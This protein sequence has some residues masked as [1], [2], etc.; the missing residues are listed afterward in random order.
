MILIS[1]FMNEDAVARLRADFEVHHDATLVDDTQRLY[2]A[3]KIADALIVRNRTQVDARCSR[4]AA[5]A[6]RRPARRRPRQHRRRQRAR[7]AH[8]SHSGYRRQRGAVAEYVIATA[9]LLLRGAYRSSAESPRTL[10]AGRCR[11][12]ARSPA[13]RSDWSASA[14]RPRHCAREHSARHARRRH[15][16]LL[17]RDDAGWREHDVERELSTQCWP[18]PTSSRCTFRSTRRRAT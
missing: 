16:A 14:H 2:A 15:D 13:R 4:R 11:K 6:R 17:Q 10:A 7:R 1:E 3:V 5:V 12:A 18:R 9:M 8:R